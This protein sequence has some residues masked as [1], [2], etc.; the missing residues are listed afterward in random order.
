MDF[1]ELRKKH[2]QLVYEGFQILPENGNLKVIFD[3]LLAPDI[4]FNPVIIFPNFSQ[5]R[6]NEIDSQVLANLVFNIGMVELLSYWKA[7]CPPQIIIKAGFLDQDQIAFWKNL[8]VKGLGEFFYNNKIDFTRKDLVEF[9]VE[10]AESF[11]LY[12]CELRDRDLVL[13][14][15]GKDSSVTLE[16]ISKKGKEFQCLLLNPTEAAV[17]IAKVGG[18][19]NPIIVK[20]TIDPKLLKLNGQGYLN[21]HTPFSAYLAF[22]STLAGVLYD[23]K[24]LVVSN[25]ASSNEGNVVW[26]GQEINHQYSKT[27]EFEQDFRYYSKNYLSSSANYFSFLRNLGEL[28]ISEKFSKMEKYHKL[29]RSCNSG[30]KQGVWCGKCPKCVSTYLLLYPFLGQKTADIFGKDLL[31]DEKL[32]PV[33]RGLL[34]ENNQVKPFECVATVN[35]IKLAISL[36]IKRAKKDGQEIP[37]I[38]QSFQKTLILG[39]GREGKSTLDYFKKQS[40]D[41]KIGIADQS[42]GEDYLEKIKDYDLIIK[43]PGIPY[44]PEIR[45][46]KRQGKII[47]SATQIFFENFKGKIIGVTGTKGKSTTASLIYEVL[48]NGGL[49]AYLI[50]N[51]G[52][53]ALDLLNKLGENS[54][55]VYEL[56]S[57]QLEDLEKSPQWAVLT[58]IYPE[59]LDHHKD[60]SLYI[61]AKNNITKYQ[62]KKDYLIYNAEIPELKIIAKGSKAQKIPFSKKDQRIVSGLIHKDTIPLLGEFNLL[63]VVPAIIIGRLFKITDTKIEEAII[64]FKPLPHRLEFITEAQGV[65]FYN[66]S[67]STIPEAT[68]A[69]LSALG[70]NVETLIAGGYDR[71]LDFSVLGQAIAKSKIKNL[72]LFPDTGT[73]IWKVVSLKIKN[74]KLKIRKFDTDSMQ[75]AVEIAFK[76]TNPGK[77]VL[78]SPASTSFNLFK[79]Y[80][81]RGNQFKGW[82][83]K[84]GTN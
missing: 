30:S 39:F 42:D 6:V 70:E 54:I 57:F 52:K 3:F 32:I 33:V 46:A 36:G 68:A 60:F 43:S 47:T 64:N 76:R 22:L 61:E 53:P 80:E 40:P 62:T 2:N 11:S 14:G 49:D 24:N 7:A 31:E 72:I 19:E 82:V 73:K 56:S 45:E 75:N 1:N 28:Q 9:K 84:L 12:E 26:L 67:L 69:A 35:E 77:I 34:R 20:R 78:L 58:N 81:D 8:L 5:E 17:K 27:S 48:K 51:I 41:I 37:K 44:L 13:V 59:H 55:V 65:R 25:E 63:N 79:D 15:G 29:F 4:R 83:K 50:G 38:L 21:G 18:C 71:G 66:D 16:S 10:S 74:L 23:Y